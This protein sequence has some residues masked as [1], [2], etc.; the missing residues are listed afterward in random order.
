MRSKQIL[1]FL[2]FIVIQSY[3]QKSVVAAY[4]NVS[5]Q[6]GSVTFSIGQVVN[7]Y[8]SN[9]THSI[10]QGVQQPFEISVLNVNSPIAPAISLSAYPN[11]TQDILTLETTNFEVNN[12]QYH[13]IGLNGTVLQNQ[14]ITSVKSLI[15]FKELP[16]GV[17]LL[18]VTQENKEIKTFKIIKN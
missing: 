3:S 18:K 2:F 11:P 4:G 7:N 9:P 15:L 13:L 16:V 17:Y 5:N 12:F 14:K 10:N 6:T 1:L 8:E